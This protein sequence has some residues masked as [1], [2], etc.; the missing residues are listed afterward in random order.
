MEGLDDIRG[1]PIDS[2]RYS[3]L[4]NANKYLELLTP[5]DK[6]AKLS[7]ESGLWTTELTQK[8]TFSYGDHIT[9]DDLEAIAATRG[10]GH[11]I[12][13]SPS[14]SAKQGNRIGYIIANNN[15][16]AVKQGNAPCLKTII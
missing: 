7:G 1:S 8:Y 3:P 14:D 5:W 15:P 9:A 12:G 11:M 2:R 16:D 13:N 10:L 6:D 4:Y